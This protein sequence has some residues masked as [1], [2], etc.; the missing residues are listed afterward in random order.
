[1][2]E[3]QPLL[4]VNGV[5]VVYDRAA[6]VLKSVSLAVPEG[7]VVAL[8]GPNGAG[9][10][11]TMKAVANLLRA[12][13]GEVTRGSIVYDGRRID[14][15]GAADLA[16][17]GLSLVME[18]RHCFASLSV[19]ENLRVGAFTRRDGRA[20]VAD[21]LDLVYR[22]FPRLKLRRDSP[23]GLLSGGEQQMC[24]IGRALMAKPRMILL[25]E[26]SMGLA[27]QLVDE[28][29]EI[30]RRLN[31]EEGVSFLLAEQNAAAALRYATHA[32]LLENGRVVLDGGAASLR[33]DPVV[34]ASYLGLD[35]DGRQTFRDP[36]AARPRQRWLCCGRWRPE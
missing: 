34:Q 25:D 22:C 31:R 19:E 9:K 28:I 35:A 16:P 33:A 18:G 13:R 7:G 21:S 30:L 4:A 24:A 11:T 15:L 12:D 14:R 27:P 23:A 32:Y 6:L 8:L 3:T 10:S 36:A 29:F 26:P 17:R 20:A 5:E 2:S 1:M